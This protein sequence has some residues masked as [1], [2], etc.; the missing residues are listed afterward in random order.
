M[1]FI[2]ESDYTDR[3]QLFSRITSSVM[4]RVNNAG[5]RSQS[6]LVWYSGCLRRKLHVWETLNRNKRHF[7]C[8]PSL[9]PFWLDFELL[10]IC[11]LFCLLYFG[12]YVML[13]YVV[14]VK[15]KKNVDTKKKKQTFGFGINI[16]LNG[17]V[18]IAFSFLKIWHLGIVTAQ[19][20]TCVICMSTKWLYV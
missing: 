16:F 10:S 8:L 11:L 2:W 4:A 9:P 7:Y 1:W 13:C 3:A 12:C 15:K 17:K 18:S 19:R 20:Q 6:I 5:K 14:M